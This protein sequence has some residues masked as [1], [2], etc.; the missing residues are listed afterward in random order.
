MARRSDGKPRGYDQNQNYSD[1]VPGFGSSN[2]PLLE[3]LNS[4]L[5]G[6]IF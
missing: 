1:V 6:L 4:L 3:Q 5:L 2:A